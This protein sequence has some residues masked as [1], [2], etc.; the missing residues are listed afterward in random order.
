MLKRL[1]LSKPTQHWSSTEDAISIDAVFRGPEQLSSIVTRP[2]VPTPFAVALQIHESAIENAFSVMLAGRTLN[3]RRLNELLEKV[4]RLKP[5]GS[6]DESEPPFE[7]SFSRSRPVIF[8]ARNQSL[9]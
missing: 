8:E 5:A 1:S 7:I 4:G 6:D 9:R 2:D 3:E